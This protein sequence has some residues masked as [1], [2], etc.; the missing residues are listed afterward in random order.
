MDCRGGVNTVRVV[1]G[2][3][4][5]RQNGLHS[6]NT[7]IYGF[8]LDFT[9]SMGLEKMTY[10]C[11]IS[12]GFKALVFK[13]LAFMLHLTCILVSRIKANVFRQRSSYDKHVL[14]YERLLRNIYN[15]PCIY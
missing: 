2:H 1:H 15:C 8:R 6:E 14:I 4:L 3:N 12:C 5:Q 9:I 7:F 10:L 11:F 13:F